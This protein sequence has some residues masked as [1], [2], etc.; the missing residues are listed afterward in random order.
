MSLRFL[1]GRSGAG[2]TSN[3]LDEIRSKL[4]EDPEGNPIIYLVPDQMTFLSEYKLIKTPGLAGM[5]RTQV[6]SFSRLAWR[7]LQETGGMSRL[8]LDSVGVNML[9]RKIMDDKKEELKMFR[10]SADKQGF[11][12][13]MEL[14]L[15]EFKQ[16]CIQPDDIQNYLAETS[17]AG[18]GIQDK[19]HDLEL[20]YQAFE[21][22]MV[23]KYLD[24]EDYFTLLIEKMSESSY[25]RNADIYIDG[26]YSLTPQELLIV[27]E[28]MKLC[29]SVTISL[30]LDQPY[31][32][33]A[34]DDLQLFRQTGNLYHHLY[35]A[36]LRNGIPISEDRILKGYGKVWKES[37]AESSGN[38]F[39]HSS[40]T[41]V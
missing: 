10:R 41:N 13:Q 40:C 3:I 22:E 15:A 38:L 36:G 20:V 30:T 27:E 28:M 31:R 5:I 18:S 14:M 21:D 6:F 12:A 33:Y 16:Y 4:A 29:R 9:I 23:N 8:H 34:P 24:S 37:G 35:Q 39:C 1:L 32:Q 25:I 2:K 7:V 11:I 19:L 17:Q 26:F